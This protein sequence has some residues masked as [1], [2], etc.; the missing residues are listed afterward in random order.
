MSSIYNFK[1]NINQEE[2]ENISNILKEGGIVVFPT[3]TVYGIGADATNDKAVEKIFK[4]KGRPQDN[5]LIV[6]ISDYEMLKYVATNINSIE[7]KLM[8]KF[9]PGPLTIILKSSNNVAKSVTA[10]LDTVGVRMPSNN[11]ALKIIETFNRPIAAPSANISGRPS[12]TKLEDIYNELKDRVDLFVDEAFAV[13][14]RKSASNYGI[15]QIL[16][17]YEGFLM[18]KEK[19]SL[20]LNDKKKPILAILGGAKVS[21]KIKLIS[22]LIDKVEYI[23]V[24]GAMAFTFLKALGKNVGKSIVEDEC[25]ELA[26]EIMN[27]A[28]NSNVDFILPKD[29]VVSTSVDNENNATMKNVEDISSVDMGLDIGE[30][31]ILELKKYIEKA[32]TIFWNGPLGV[33]TNKAFENGTK[34]IALSLAKCSAYTIVG[35]GDSVDAIEK[36]NLEEKINFVSTGGGAS[37]K[38]IQNN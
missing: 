38:Y 9:W 26:K 3:E 19:K 22:N 6:H 8:D 35:G 37:L 21:D 7:K 20:C 5:P 24:G 30:Q 2:L 15:S 36:Y 17:S 29:V 13:S 16:P 23:F 32:Q 31:T 25:L 10:G 33:Y 27:K 12:G 1:E 34:Q 11:I 18:Q 4:A 28:K 14:H